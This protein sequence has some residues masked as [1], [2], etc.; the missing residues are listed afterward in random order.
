MKSHKILNILYYRMLR[1]DEK[2]ALMANLAHLLVPG[3]Q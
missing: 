2:I 3:V 1:K